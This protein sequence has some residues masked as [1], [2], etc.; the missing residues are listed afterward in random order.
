MSSKKSVRYESQRNKADYTHHPGRFFELIWSDDT[1]PCYLLALDHRQLSLLREMCAVFPKYHW[2]WGLPSPQ[3]NWD[4]ATQQTWQDISTFVEELEATLLS[5]CDLQ[6]FIDAQIEQT[7][8]IRELTAVIGS[9]DL[10]LTQP[11]P[12]NPQYAQTG[13]AGKFRTSNWVAQDENLADI[14]ANSLFGRYIDPIPDPLT[15]DGISDILD[16]VLTILHNRFRMADGSLFNPLNDEK[17]VT[18]TLE[19]LFRRDKFTDLEFLTP[20]LATIFENTMNTGDSGV[21]TMLK[22]LVSR[23]A[24]ELNLPPEVE[25]WLETQLETNERLSTA[26]ILLLI[27]SATGEDGAAGIAKAIKEAQ[28]T[29]NLNNYNGCC[30]E[31]DC[32][33]AGAD[34][35]TITVDDLCEEE[36]PAEPSPNGSGPGV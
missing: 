19:T 15:G 13:L 22:S 29:I 24:A 20:N 27:A 4:A 3:A 5:G 1:G 7:K 14:L 9:L 26:Q 23:I 8:A 28:T 17:N 35:Q 10:D 6:A 21:V 2:V 18:E 12:D 34:T 16:D 36:T 31:A 33:C 32:D 25:S 11:V 30:D